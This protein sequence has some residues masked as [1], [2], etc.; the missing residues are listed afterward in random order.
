MTVRLSEWR[1][2]KLSSI[3]RFAFVEHVR[4]YAFA[5]QSL[6]ILRRSGCWCSWAEYNRASIISP[7]A[8][9]RS[10]LTAVVEKIRSRNDSKLQ[11]STNSKCAWLIHLPRTLYIPFP[12]VSHADQ[13]SS[14]CFDICKVLSSQWQCQAVKT[15]RSLQVKYKA[16]QWSFSVCL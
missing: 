3:S 15:G 4:R 16:G 13:A 11:L 8:R 14:F 6:L 5:L 1:R 7:R 2:C 9:T 12:V 10:R